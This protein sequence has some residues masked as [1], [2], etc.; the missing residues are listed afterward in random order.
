MLFRAI[1]DDLAEYDSATLE[2][3][4]TTWAVSGLLSAS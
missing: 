3:P 2:R 4:G 1:M